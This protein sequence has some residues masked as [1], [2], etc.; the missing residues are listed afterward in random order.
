MK[1]TFV[2]IV[3]S[4]VNIH[5]FSQETITHYLS[6]TD[7]DHTVPWEFFCT[8]GR[9]SGAW[10]TIPVPSNW[11][12]Q[13]FGDFVYGWQ[14]EKA[15]EQ[16]LYKCTFRTDNKWL[17]KKV[18]IVFEGVLTD[19][20]VKINGAVAGDVHQG[21]YY[22]FSYDITSLLKWDEPNV[23]EVNV[24]KQSANAS[25][26]RAERGGDFWALGGIYRP[27]YLSI[28][29]DV[30]IEH[31]AVNAQADGQITIDAL[32][33]N[34]KKGYSIEAQVQ[35]LKGN[36]IGAPFRVGAADSVLLKG[37]VSNIKTWNPETPVLYQ[38]KISLKEGAKNIHTI[39]QRF[40]FRTVEFRL[41][42]GFYV[43]GVR[44]IFKGVNRHSTWP[45]TGKALS[46]DIHLLDVAL[47]KDMNMNAVRMSHYP[48]DQAFLDIC[49]SLGLFVIDELT[50]WQAAYDTV[51]GRKLVKELVRRDVNHPSV[52]IWSNG[53]EG[54]W[55]RALDGDFGW[56][57]PQKRF[58]M[59]PWEKF[60]GTET[61]HYPDFNYITNSV[62]YGDE[63]YYPT[64]FMHGWYDGGHGAGLDDC[65]NEMLK[66]PFFAGGFL[67]ALHDEGIVRA[68][69]NDS[70]DTYGPAAPDGIVGP[71]REKEGS[72]YTI[73][74]IW[75]PVVMHTKTIPAQFNGMLEVENRY[76]YTN[77]NKCTFQWK[78]VMFPK[79]DEDSTGAMELQKGTAASFSLAPGEKGFLKLPFSKT[80]ADALYV[81]AYD[82]KGAAI[83]T[84]SWPLHSPQDIVQTIPEV[85]S[86]STLFVVE[87][88]VSLS[89]IDDGINYIFDKNTGYLV[90]VLSGKKEISLSGGPALAGIDQTLV[91]FTHYEQ[92]KTHI[93][94]PVYKGDSRYMVKWI[95]KSGE[96]PR[97]DYAYTMKG[98]KDFMGIT[99]NYPEEKITGM[100]WLGQ[101]PYRVWKNRLKGQMLGV[102]QKAYNNTVT[103]ESW[104]YP[105]FSG[106]HA[107]LYWVKVQNKENDFTIYTNQ[108]NMFLQMGRPVKPKAA[109]NDYI[110]PPFP[111]A[112]LGMMHGI[113]AI[114]TKFHA[115]GEYGPQSRKNV[116]LNAP[117]TGSLWF[118]FR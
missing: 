79:A 75:S 61:K 2:W 42:D 85:S 13:G 55:N 59:H 70:I 58:V 117:F 41:R 17:R 82:A 12:M 56:Y 89:L 50:G 62:L 49:D 109:Y 115:A 14:K 107:N 68:D 8:K 7:K 4:L 112:T 95:F 43:N 11:E 102:W 36:A 88:S 51:A 1:K 34:T 40:G 32:T 19:A 31:V 54:G 27:V 97:L 80:N 74:E 111:A 94:E 60:N 9:K 76:L 38:L 20:E 103:G 69:K 113:S 25:V 57:D 108:R 23:L 118:D 93:I 105:E 114:G 104:L 100:K 45:E 3:L 90:K 110:N 91:E 67:W 64:E 35:D 29:P 47:M 44:V 73:K 87:D 15:D 84:W 81:T 72:Y 63:V 71:H 26:N 65:W 30:F 52:V 48:P 33:H 83:F 10:T 53:N 18:F 16:G 21:G 78:L 24:S 101:G 39:T 5:T 46:N 66:H 96:L 28:V 22:Q 86:M 116:Q 77:L 99:F 92:D 6:G 106:W 37:K 98:E